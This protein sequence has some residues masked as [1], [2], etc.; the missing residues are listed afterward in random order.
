M[1]C[2]LQGKLPR[3]LQF[4]LQKAFGLWL[5]GQKTVSCNWAHQKLNVKNPYFLF[6]HKVRQRKKLRPQTV[7]FIAPLSSLMK[8][9]ALHCNRT[10]THQH[11]HT[12]NEI[13]VSQYRQPSNGYRTVNSPALISLSLASCPVLSNTA[14]DFKV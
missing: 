9:I 8:N 6:F 1:C 11:T 14:A 4:L 7:K 10:L 12:S 13:H 2:F 3:F 5:L